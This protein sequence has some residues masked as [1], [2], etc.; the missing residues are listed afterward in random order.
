MILRG[1]AK[2]MENNAIKRNLRLVNSIVTFKFLRPT[3]VLGRRRPT[4]SIIGLGIQL[5]LVRV[6]YS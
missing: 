5:E 4:E 2:V 6:T 1:T 3:Y